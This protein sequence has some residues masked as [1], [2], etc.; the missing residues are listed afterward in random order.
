[1]DA[2]GAASETA[3]PLARTSSSLVEQPECSYPEQQQHMGVRPAVALGSMAALLAA[4]AGASAPFIA[5]G[6]LRSFGVPYNPTEAL[7]LRAMLRHLPRQ[8]R[9]PAGR[10]AVG[11]C[12]PRPPRVVVDL[13]SG[14]GRVVVAMAQR[15][16]EAH[17]IEFNPWLVA[18]SRAAALGAGVSPALSALRGRWGVS[19]VNQ[20]DG[21]GLAS[22][23]CGNMWGAELSRAD[24][25]VIYGV[26]Q[27]MPRFGAKLQAEARPGTV[28]LSNTFEIPGWERRLI[29]EEEGVYVY[30]WCGG[31]K[32]GES[33]GGRR[34]RMGAHWQSSK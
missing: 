7:K 34:T 33:K 11:T 15:G 24:A 22:F 28:V 2:P 4:I 14:D 32:Q 18:W 27:L 9:G 12:T 23:V 10:G 31:G 13:G 30:R 3:E 26:E 17:G 5:P 16:Y 1:M 8:A 25:V 19:G 20:Q 21:V 29:A 6:V